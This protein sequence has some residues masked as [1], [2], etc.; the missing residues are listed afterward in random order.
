MNDTLFAFLITLVSGLTMGLGATVVFFLKS[1]NKRAVSFCMGFSAGAMLLIA[2]AGLLPETIHSL[3][4]SLE[5]G[6]R[7]LVYTM[8]MF[9]AGLLLML[10]VD[11]LLP[12][13]AHHHPNSVPDIKNR[14]G[15]SDDSRMLRTGFAIAVAIGVHNIPEGIATFTA[16]LSDR[17]LGLMVAL[18]VVLHNIPIGIAIAM[19]IYVATKNKGKAFGTA[20]L[21]GLVSPVAAAVFYLLMMPFVSPV[22]ISS[23]L[24]LV[25]GIMVYI[26]IDELIPAS[27]KMG[28]HHLSTY[29]IVAGMVFLAVMLMFMGGHQH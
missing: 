23:L 29:G 17:G 4:H 26:S 12:S 15:E 20:L 5:D 19:P 28:Y 16:A 8:L 13:H 3:E 22:F 10:I 14:K 24:A 18:A 1:E 11:K 27:R 9:V 6:S 7:A 2:F 25:A 21:S